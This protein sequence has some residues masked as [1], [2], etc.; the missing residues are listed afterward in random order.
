MRAET[1]TTLISGPWRQV[2]RPPPLFLRDR[3]RPYHTFHAE[4]TDPIERL[5]LPR[6]ELVL[7]LG[8]GEPLS[9]EPL[10]LTPSRSRLESFVMGPDHGPLLG[11]H[12]GRRS[13]IDIGIPPWAAAEIFDGAAL[14]L[15]GGAVP[16]DEFLGTAGRRL[17]ERLANARA[18]PERFAALDAF[19]VRRATRAR[20]RTRPEIRWAWEQL[21][22]SGG[23]I[24]VNVLARAI[25]WSH[26][27]L[28]ACFRTQTGMT[29]KVAARRIRLKR[30]VGKLDRHPGADISMVAAVSDYADQSHL[31]REFREL[32]GCTPGAYRRHL[33][34]GSARPILERRQAAEP[35]CPSRWT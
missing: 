4:L 20:R 2:L 26:R 35:R 17:Q 18:W 33:L 21:E 5:Q 7:V 6:G 1:E 31:T 9:L 3:V 27:H 8:L 19:L 32:A 25:G 24:P 13:C 12:H 29:P 14:E 34:T 16:L 28:V 22:R 23:R 11:R 30:A 10:G 15:G